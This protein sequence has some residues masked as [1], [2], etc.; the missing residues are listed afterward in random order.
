MVRGNQSKYEKWVRWFDAVRPD[1][2]FLCY[3]RHIYL[4]VQ[5]MVELNPNLHAPSSFWPFFRCNYA[6][7]AAIAVRRLVKHHKDSHSFEGLLDDMAQ[8]PGAMTVMMYE[9]LYEGSNRKNMARRDFAAFSDGR[10]EILDASMLK[11]DLATLKGAAKKIMDFADKR[12][13]HLDRK[14]AI[15]NPTFDELHECISIID[16]LA[17]KYQC[18]LLGA[19]SDSM[20]PTI[21]DDWK[22]IFRVPWISLDDDNGCPPDHVNSAAC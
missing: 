19:Y 3:S 20:T 10:G 17:C 6:A 15:Y 2:K 16:G 9:K 5:R 18:L 22:A 11:S 12:V 8:N 14:A 1:V 4:E 13:A 7:S 21:Q